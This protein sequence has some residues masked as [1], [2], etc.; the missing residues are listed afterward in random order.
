MNPYLIRQLW[1]LIEASHSH[2]LLSLDDNNLVRWLMERV[3]GESALNPQEVDTLNHYIWSR[4]SLIRD[5][6]GSR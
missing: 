4:L 1:S 5:V 2:V 3:L 6:V